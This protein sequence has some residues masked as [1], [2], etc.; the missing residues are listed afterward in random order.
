MSIE[1]S[2]IDGYA[3]S[4]SKELFIEEQ[5]RRQFWPQTGRSDREAGCIIFAASG[6]GGPLLSDP[7]SG[8]H[9]ENIRK[10]NAASP[11]R[12]IRSATPA[13]LTPGHTARK[14]IYG[15]R[16]YISDWKVS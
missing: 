1:S 13:R 6:R 3:I 14:Y 10:L 7:H 16:S 15:R 9:E 4:P 12:A 5:A 8:A 11:R 2:D